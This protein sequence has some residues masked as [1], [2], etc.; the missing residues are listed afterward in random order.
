MSDLNTL[1]KIISAAVSDDLEEL[2]IRILERRIN[3]LEDIVEEMCMELDSFYSDEET[4]SDGDD[5]KTEIIITGKSLPK[6]KKSSSTKAKKSKKKK[7]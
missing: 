1:S 2:K 5:A 6:R 3:D 7:D 4:E